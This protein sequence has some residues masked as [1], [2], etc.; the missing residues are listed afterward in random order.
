MNVVIHL[1][2]T[3]P[4]EGTISLRDHEQPAKDGPSVAFAGWL[5]LVTCLYDLLGQGRKPGDG[6]AAQPG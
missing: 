4:P 3:E 6:S 5:G 1:L 2:R